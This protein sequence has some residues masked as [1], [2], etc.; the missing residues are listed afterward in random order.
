[1]KLTVFLPSFCYFLIA[2]VYYGT[3]MRSIWKGSISFGLVNIPVRLYSATD[4]NSISFDYLHKKDLSP[5][6]YAKVCKKEE[7]EI[8]YKEVVRG[9][10]FRPG[11]FVVITD[12][13]L[14]K[15]NVERSK[16]ID[17]LSFADEDQIDSKYFEKPYYLEPEKNSEKAYLLLL[18]ALKTSKKVGIAKFVLRVREHLCALKPQG[19]MLILNQMRF[20]NEVR[21]AEE[22][23]LPETDGVKKTEVEMAITLIKQLAKPFNIEDYED[24]YRK[25][26]ESM[27]DAKA[28][29]KPIHIEGE[30]PQPTKVKD[31]M[32]LLKASIDQQGAAAS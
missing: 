8:S 4:D 10:E 22:L 21:S 16:T 23:N 3:P 2:L 28:K 1:M 12:D 11:D 30:E 15:V 25:E 17:I 13:D 24:T 19:N 9:Y 6:R 27:L 7:T 14:K 18:E 26:L 5:V 29:G 32:D 31:L 20:A